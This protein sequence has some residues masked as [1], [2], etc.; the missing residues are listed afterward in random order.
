MS[1]Q[2]ASGQRKK[3]GARRR[4]K[5]R[6][7]LLL[8]L[9]GAMVTMLWQALRSSLL[10]Q[11]PDA[12]AL[13]LD[14]LASALA[15]LLP[16]ALGLLLVDGDQRRLVPARALTAE[17]TWRLAL[18]G[19]LCAAPVTLLVNVLAALAGMQS[20]GSAGMAVGRDAALLIPLLLKS[21][22][23]VPLCEEL[24]FRGYLLQVLAPYGRRAAVLATALLF[25]LSHVG[26][27]MLPVALLGVL[28]AALTLRTGSL[29]APLLV[30]G[31]YNGAIVLISFSGL[32]PLFDRLSLL[33]CALRVAMCAGLARE[34][35]LAWRARPSCKRVCLYSGGRLSIREGL[36]L[37]LALLAMLAAAVLPFL[38][39]EAT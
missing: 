18:A 13:A 16:A 14:T 4:V 2:Q 26:R 37:L 39:P 33:S 38:L 19:V 20:A 31:A 36:L 17:Q 29:L 32:S 35:S 8:T 9:W 10:A 23:L 30:H 12:A 27:G 1:R 28:L 21:M 15:W 6:S 24:F 25:A 5:M 22:L 11:L 34:L 3:N 7:A